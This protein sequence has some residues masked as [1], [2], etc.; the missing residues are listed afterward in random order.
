MKIQEHLFLRS[1][2]ACD[3][4]LRSN[5]IVIMDR[6]FTFYCDVIVLCWTYKY[7]IFSYINITE[8]FWGKTLFT[9]NES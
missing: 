9:L 1:L 7:Y 5:F 6:N 2:I 4:I 3:L 8:V